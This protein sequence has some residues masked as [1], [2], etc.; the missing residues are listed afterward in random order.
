MKCR[1]CGAPKAPHRWAIDVCA[2][3]NKQRVFYLCDKHDFELNEHVLR[4]FHVPGSY[5]KT[6]RYRKETLDKYLAQ[7]AA[8]DYAGK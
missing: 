8:N 6:L 1:T 4:F 5:A 2:D 3:N 7:E